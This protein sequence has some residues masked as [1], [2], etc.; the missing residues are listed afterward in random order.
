[1]SA[2]DSLI[3]QRPRQ[4][5]VA[6]FGSPNLCVVQ[7]RSG[8]SFQCLP[9]S[10]P[11]SKLTYSKSAVL[12]RSPTSIGSATSVMSSPPNNKK[13]IKW[14]L[15]DRKSTKDMFKRW[16]SFS[17]G[18]GESKEIDE[19]V[20]RYQQQQ[21]QIRMQQQESKKGNWKVHVWCKFLTGNCEI[22]SRKS[23]LKDAFFHF[24]LTFVSI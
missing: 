5:S 11:F 1:M 6:P 10:N 24:A 7:R 20:G 13:S 18:K 9:D 23:N 12:Y 2:D 22:Q 16:Q 8:G 17:Q 14:R 21:E 4:S 15:G 3:P 19:F